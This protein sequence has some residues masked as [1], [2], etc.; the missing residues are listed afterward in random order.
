VKVEAPLDSV[1][2]FVRAGGVISVVDPSVQTL[3][4][5]SNSSVV[6]YYDRRGVHSPRPWSRYN[7]Y[8]E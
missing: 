8:E 6:S 5:A 7:I 3:S 4:H 2:L 1:P